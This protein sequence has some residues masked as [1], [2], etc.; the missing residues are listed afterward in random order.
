MHFS[1]IHPFKLD[2]RDGHAQVAEVILYEPLHDASEGSEF[3]DDALR[4]EDLSITPY[5]NTEE[6]VAAGSPS[7]LF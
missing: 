1:F 5:A 3:L 4:M 2:L 7:N 6:S